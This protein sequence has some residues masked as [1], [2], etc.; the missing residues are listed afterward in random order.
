MTV[1][2]PAPE[3]RDSLS[4][5]PLL[6]TGVVAV[7][8]FVVLLLLVELRVPLWLDLEARVRDVLTA[9]GGAERFALTLHGWGTVPLFLLASLTLTV[10]SL[11]RRDWWCAAAALVA[12]LL[13]G[14]GRTALAAWLDR[15]RPAGPHSLGGGNAFPSGHAAEAA[16]LA[17]LVVI[18]AIVLLPRAVARV[19]AVVALAWVLLSGWGRLALGAHWLGDVLAGWAFGIA[20]VALLVGASRVRTSPPPPAVPQTAAEPELGATLT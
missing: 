5:R 11:V 14:A 13:L 6:R 10:V 15:P 2:E 18:V 9:S 16:G 8:V 4:A 20:V 19:L 12:G 3:N 7:V 17:S 1:P